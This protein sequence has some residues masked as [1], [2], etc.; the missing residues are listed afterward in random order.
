VLR[1]SALISLQFG[2]APL[3][4]MKTTFL[5]LVKLPYM[6]LE[7]V[8][9]NSSFSRFIGHPKKVWIGIAYNQT[10]QPPLCPAEACCSFLRERRNLTAIC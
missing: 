9:D 2:Q 4:N 10:D 3:E 5:F 7:A 8:F 1:N 6:G